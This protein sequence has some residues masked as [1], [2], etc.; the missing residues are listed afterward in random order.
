MDALAGVIHMIHIYMYISVGVAFI[1]PSQLQKK[2]ER[3]VCYSPVF[4]PGLSLLFSFVFG[5][6]RRT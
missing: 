1:N 4:R 5:A 3:R 2:E 6:I